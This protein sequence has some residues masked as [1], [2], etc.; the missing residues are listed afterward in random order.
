M[1]FCRFVLAAL[2]LA[3]SPLSARR[4]AQI[5]GTYPER[6][7]EELF[8]SRQAARVRAGV[9]TAAPAPAL[10]QDFGHIAVLDDAGGLVARRN[11]FNLE[12]RQVRFLPQDAGITRY[13]FE[14]SDGGYDDAAARAGSPVGGLGDD[15]GREFDLPFPFTFFGSTYNK[16]FLNS[17]GNL[18]F[19]LSDPASTDRSL[20]RLTAGPPRI[21][22]LFSD[23]DP[24][25]A[26]GSVRV[27]AEAHRWVASWVAVP[28]FSDFGIGPPRTVQI[29]LF[30]DGKIEFAWGTA[31]LPDAV[32][33][34]S[35]G[36]VQGSTSLVSF[37]GG[38][39]E[40]FS[41][42]IAERFGGSMEVDT[43]VTA[44]RFYETHDDAYDYLVIFNNMGITA[45]SGAV[46]YEVTARNHRLGIGDRLVDAGK[47]YG[48]PRR[49]QAVLN[50]GPL[51]QYP[52]DPHAFVPSR[53]ASRDTPL[54][55]L[56]HEA[57]H[58]F[59]AFA[60]V[61]D[62]D[63]RKP[64]LGRQSAHWAFT[65][66]S[67]ASILEG[68][69]IQDNGENISPRFTTVGAAEGYSLL[70]QYLMGLRA[71]DEVGPMFYVAEPSIGTGNRS[72]QLG[73]SFDGRRRDVRIEEIIDVE[74]RRTPDHTVAQ[75]YFRFAFI[76]IT[77][78][79]TNVPQAHLDQI[80][81]YRREFESFFNRASGQR[82]SAEATLQRSLH[83]SVFP[84]AGVLASGT[85][86]ATVSISRAS[87][88]PLTVLLG[89]SQGTA[90][91]P[92]SITIAA[93]STSAS[94]PVHGIRPGI[95]LLEA[96]PEDDRYATAHARMAV[97]EPAELAL[98]VTSGDRQT[99]TPGVALRQPI[100]IRVIDAN[101]L[102]YPGVAIRATVSGG[103]NVEPQ[104]AVTSDDGVVRFRWTPGPGPVEEL[105]GGVSGK[106]PSSDGAQHE[107]SR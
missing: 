28:E 14:V 60:S 59:L 83:L 90:E 3:G 50:M 15:D 16:V 70:D 93:G 22:G 57:G 2:A 12:S 21:A 26:S 35:P 62:E 85:A 96:R 107:E 20:G 46:A 13:R 73:V 95:E 11:D 25:R 88:V 63:N 66:N 42:T 100:E 79:G 103:G 18:T 69:R 82:A 19:N 80:D 27:Q 34:I 61:L 55:I 36:G 10:S 23:L 58:L 48:S 97:S 53:A 104:T 51:S 40:P 77:S 89:A 65:F 78:A 99:V 102:P 32:V 47:Q 68:N 7:Q 54:T 71:P 91:V 43:V 87:T 98:A 24:S 38:S 94:F 6:A 45:G 81:S 1:K 86:T 39:S 67:E 105:R 29:R 56:G 9:R 31:R 84:A 49:L 72:P 44:Q 30:P 76:L 92:A 75:R 17:D 33:G 4:E 8:L 37:L 101:N 41:A 74:G 52:L 106:R 5:C 64:M